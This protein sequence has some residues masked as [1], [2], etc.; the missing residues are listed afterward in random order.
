MSLVVQGG[1]AQ[2]L[3]PVKVL[4]RLTAAFLVSLLA[5]L[6]SR[7]EQSVVELALR[8]QLAV[9]AQ[10]RPRPRVTSLDRAFWLALRRL[11]PRWKEVLVV[12]PETIV[13]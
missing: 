1:I 10:A 12:G 6:R 3:S 7:A 8:Q 5:F 9:Y 2:D 11:W 13:R 4:L